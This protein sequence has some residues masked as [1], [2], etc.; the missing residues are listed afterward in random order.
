V[1]FTAIDPG[2]IHYMTALVLGGKADADA[3]D[4]QDVGTV[5][6]EDLSEAGSDFDGDDPLHPGRQWARARTW[7]RNTK[8]HRNACAFHTRGSARRAQRADAADLS[9]ITS[10]PSCKTADISALTDHTRAA[11]AAH[12]SGQAVFGDLARRRRRFNVHCARQR[13]FDRDAQILA[14]GTTTV[15]GRPL[16]AAP[17]EAPPGRP[18]APEHSCVWGRVHRARLPHFPQRRWPGARVCALVLCALPLP[19]FDCH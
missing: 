15:R 3:F 13:Q 1:H 9:S 5:G 18:P 8:A 11:A 6:A 17:L 16:V 10:V 19:V 14:R 12:A 7:R 2:L 4:Y